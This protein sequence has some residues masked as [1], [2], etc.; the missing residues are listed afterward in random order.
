M[1]NIMIIGPVNIC[2]QMMPTWLEARYRF[3][4]HWYIVASL[5]ISVCYGNAKWGENEQPTQRV[6]HCYVGGKSLLPSSTLRYGVSVFLVWQQQYNRLHPVDV[7]SFYHPIG[8]HLSRFGDSFYQLCNTYAIKCI[9]IGCSAV[10]FHCTATAKSIPLPLM[11][12]HGH[13]L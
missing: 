6:S 1:L 10:V 9:S 3:L 11:S 4:T 8:Q 7:R 2:V 13:E 5:C 12:I